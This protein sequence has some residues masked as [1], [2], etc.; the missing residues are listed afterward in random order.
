METL[1]GLIVGIG[2]SAASGFRV[3]VPM[4]AISIAA[5]SGYITL[6]P[7]FEWIG[8]W[9]TLIA[10][11]TATVLEIAAYYIPVVDNIMDTVTTPA[12]VIAGTILTASMIGDMSPF[13]KWTLVIIA[14]GGV[15]GII[16]TGSV[17]LRASS[18]VKT[19]G[20]A[21][22]LVSTIE[23]AGSIL[24]TLLAFFL[25]ILCLLIVV[26]ICYMMTKKIIRRKR[27]D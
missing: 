23:V 17:A 12:A 27:A 24:I 13:L 14:G 7:G 8:T 26:L 19:G 22:S 21:N 18:S 1:L 11:T 3:F 6:S 15:A 4:M 25:P 20:A 5:L 10:F 16:Q 9:T 2:L